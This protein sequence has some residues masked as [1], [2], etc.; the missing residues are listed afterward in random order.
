MVIGDRRHETLKGRQEVTTLL[1]MMPRFITV[2][3][4]NASFGSLIVI[5]GMTTIIELKVS[6]RLRLPMR[7][8]LEE[9]RVAIAG[10]LG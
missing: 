10:L 2:L 8:A 4:G 5:V 1:N 6:L 7:V 9:A 3:T